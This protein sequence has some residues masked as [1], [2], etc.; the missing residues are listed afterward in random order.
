MRSRS[1]SL[2]LVALFALAGLAVLASLPVGEGPQASGSGAP[3]PNPATGSAAGPAP[4]PDWA[5]LSAEEA[6]AEGGEGR[7]EVVRVDPPPAAA[8]P[9]SG[10]PPLLVG[11]VVGR[12]VD[13][14][15]AGVGGARV[16]AEVGTSWFTV[17]LGMEDGGLEGLSGRVWE[18]AADPRGSFAFLDGLEPGPLRLAVRAQGFAPRALEGLSLSEARPHDLGDIALEPGVTLAG[19]VVDRG[20]AGVGGVELLSAVVRGVGG[21]QVSVPGRGVPLGRT[22][23]EGRFAVSGLAHGPWRLILDSPEHGVRGEEG[24]TR[25]PGEVQDGLLFVLEEGESVQGVVK[26]LPPELSGRARVEARPKA[27]E[28]QGRG[29]GGAIPTR[30]RRGPV[31]AGGVFRVGG[32]TPG[33]THVL[34]LW[35]LVEDV[36][37][38]GVAEGG[39]AEGGPGEGAGSQGSWRRHPSVPRAE[40]WPGARGIELEFRAATSVALRAVDAGTGAPVEDFVLWVGVERA[41]GRPRYDSLQS[42]GVGGR[43]LRHHP[44]GRARTSGLT[45]PVAGA[46]VGVLLRATGY[47]ELERRGVHLARGQELDLGTLALDPEPA[48]RITVLDGASGAPLEG[49]RVVVAGS[50]STVRWALRDLQG[51]AWANRSLRVGSTDEQGVAR[52]SLIRG[53]RCV[54]A[55]GS[56]RHTPSEPRPL[57]NP[58]GGPGRADVELTLEL[59]AGASAVVRVVDPASGPVAGVR[60]GHGAVVPGQTRGPRFRSGQDL[61]DSGFT[62]SAGRVRF[63]HLPP[64]ERRFGVLADDGGYLPSDGGADVARARLSEGR[65]SEVGLV[66]PARGA[67]SGTVTEG[68]L[69]LAGVDLKLTPAGGRARPNRSWYVVAGRDRYAALSDPH[70]RYAFGGL[71]AGEYELTLRHS[72]RLMPTSLEVVV[73]PGGTTF[74]VELPLTGIEGQVTDPEGVPLSGIQISV[75]G[76]GGD[77]GQGY[78]VRGTTLVEDDEGRMR[79]DWSSVGRQRTETDGQGRYAARGVVCDESLSLQASN[80]YVLA[81]TLGGLVIAPGEVRRGVDFVLERAGR[82]EVR[83]SGNTSGSLRVELIS[84]DEGGRRRSR[85]RGGRAQ[86][87]S[88]LRPGT[89]SVVLWREADGSR[90]EVARSEAQVVVGQLARVV[91]EVP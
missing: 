82:L 48:A 9:D 18:A 20:G 49:A 3:A 85:L 25:Q 59:D 16:W 78:W 39:A 33:I 26:G 40:A 11:R 37:D 70:G 2:A 7:R 74:D 41:D 31:G 64:G 46:T 79:P 15:G 45:L 60:V 10:P 67:L 23:G 27:G 22:D 35:H 24:R 13:G 86:T 8:E 58:G 30:V 34:T 6:S 28:L 54:V 72:D 4:G 68:G 73:V 81:G 83:A 87:F 44:G 52:V 75:S 55:A 17:P 84:Q 63:E 61:G 66:A 36:E 80:A 89:W 88:S 21:A 57:A 51:D 29:D 1:T 38:D 32:L 12:V 47:R 90:Q 5:T 71:P 53:E 19:R 42:E 50:E 91:L 65:T 62:D 77:R 69:A 56:P 14:E 43:T 76:E